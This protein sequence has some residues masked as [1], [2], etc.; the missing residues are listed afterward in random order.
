MDQQGNVKDSAKP[1]VSRRTVALGAAWSV[2]VIVMATAA[3]A[4]AASAGN[5]S[6]VLATA[7]GEKGEAVGSNR[8]V[9]FILSF[10]SIVGSNL[11]KITSIEG[12]GP[13]TVL[14][15]AAVTVDAAHPAAPFS[16]TRPDTD[17]ST[18]TVVVHYTVNGVA[19]TVSVTV[20]NKA[21]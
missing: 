10:G 2:P 14:P 13:W 4:A 12:G 11:V 1:L 17:N 5:H 3:P 21:R 16:L 6:A 19:H 8:Q 20:K 9:S 7:T 15:T 18:L